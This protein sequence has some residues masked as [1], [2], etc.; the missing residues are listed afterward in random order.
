[1]EGFLGTKEGG[2][3]ERKERKERKRER[4]K[5]RGEKEGKRERGS[6]PL[7]FHCQ[8]Q[9]VH[10]LVCLRLLRIETAMYS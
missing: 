9:L 8:Q 4:R 6:A 1:M 10:E 2:G 5:E 7:D 3:G